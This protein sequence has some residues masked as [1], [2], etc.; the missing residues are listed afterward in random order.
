MDGDSQSMQWQ[1]RKR[2]LNEQPGPSWITLI[3][4]EKVLL[5]SYF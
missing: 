3:E 1:S 5:A 4:K 2:P